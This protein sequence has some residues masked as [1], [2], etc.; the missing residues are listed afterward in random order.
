MGPL[1]EDNTVPSNAPAYKVLQMMQRRQNSRLLV[2]DGQTLKGMVTMRDIMS[3][4]AVRDELE[5]DPWQNRSRRHRSPP[6]PGA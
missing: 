6:T 5:P 4:L 3:Y 1:S 2:V